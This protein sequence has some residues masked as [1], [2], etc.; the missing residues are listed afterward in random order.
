MKFHALNDAQ[1]TCFFFSGTRQDL[2]S[3][4][5]LK[6]THSKSKRDASFLF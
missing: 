4:E 1:G 6:G 5:E 2:P 3:K